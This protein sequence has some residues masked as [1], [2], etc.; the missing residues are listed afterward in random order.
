MNEYLQKR[1]CCIPARTSNTLGEL[2][3]TSPHRLSVSVY[4]SG[5]YQLPTQPP[6]L[7]TV[8]GKWFLGSMRLGLE[9]PELSHADD[10]KQNLQSL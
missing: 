7:A 9:L 8:G 10:L 5:L 2:V 6:G 4:H 1:A 3:A